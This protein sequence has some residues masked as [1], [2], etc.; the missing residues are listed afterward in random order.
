MKGLPRILLLVLFAAALAAGRADG[1]EDT[2][3][4]GVLFW[5]DSPNDTAAYEGVKDGFRLAGMKA[6]WLVVSAGEDREAADR[7]LEAWEAAGVDLVYALGTSAALRA[8]ETIGE[9]PVVFTAVTHPVGSGVV[10]DWKGSGGRLC[11]NSN[12]IARADV[13]R[14]FQAA[15]P[16]LARLG[17]ILNPKNPVSGQE[18][19]EAKAFFADKANRDLKRKLVVELVDGPEDVAEAATKLVEAGVQA[20]WIPI[21]R[22]VYGHLDAITPVTEPAGVPLLSSQYSAVEKHRAIVG[23]AVD[24]HLLGMNSAVLAKKVLR[25]GADPGR[26]P[27]GRM[28]SFR[29]ILSLTAARRT[30][31]RVPLPLLAW[32][33][34]VLR[35]TE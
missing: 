5:H 28:K 14:V 17:V 31:Y 13:F 7:A 29:V 2:L 6:E 33:D 21:D 22:D 15:V 9:T 30:K 26:L 16:G 20:V 11:G 24:Y 27:V 32:A 12:W 34:T 23:V 1:R 35:E 3:R 18:L 4:I 25:D 10:R 8:K 19:A